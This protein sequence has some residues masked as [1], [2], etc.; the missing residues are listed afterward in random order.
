MQFLL[1]MLLCIAILLVVFILQNT[2]PVLIYMGFWEAESSLALVI[3][4]CLATGALL[5]YV[6]GIPARFRRR[7]K[8]A[9]LKKKLSQYEQVLLQERKPT[10]P[11]EQQSYHAS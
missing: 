2:T 3:L 10:D 9:D 11:M 7:K 4:G 1:F 6:V 5:T 8:I